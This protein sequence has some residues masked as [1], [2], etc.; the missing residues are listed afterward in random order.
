MRRA[1]DIFV[2]PFRHKYNHP[3]SPASQ[4]NAIE[5]GDITL[6]VWIA[7]RLPP[8]ALKLHHLSG[9]SAF[10]KRYLSLEKPPFS[11]NGSGV[12]T[13]PS[14]KRMPFLI[15]KPVS[16]CA[17]SGHLSKMKSKEVRLQL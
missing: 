7:H 3:L 12:K 15:K 10:D 16:I 2:T 9:N 8:G 11:A 14:F 5:I 4:K 13:S 6:T 1:G 17:A